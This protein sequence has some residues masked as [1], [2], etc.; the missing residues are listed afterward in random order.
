[1]TVE[2]IE[3]D[4]P[5]GPKMGPDARPLFGYETVRAYAERG[6]AVHKTIGKGNRWKW[7]VTHVAT[8]LCLER[9]GAMTKRDAMAN[10]QRAL[11]LPIDWTRGEQ[12]TLQTLRED[13]RIMDGI[14][15]IANPD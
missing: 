11:A 8:G 13:R 14:N 6:L 1:M 4:I 2:K 12:E 15:A 7:M 9:I 5:R 3:L 10:M